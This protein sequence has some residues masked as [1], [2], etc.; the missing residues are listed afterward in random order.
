MTES[1]SE[2]GAAWEEG[3]CNG[4][5]SSDCKGKCC[6]WLSPPCWCAWPTCKGKLQ[7]CDSKSFSSLL[8]PDQANCDDIKQNRKEGMRTQHM[9]FTAAARADNVCC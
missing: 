7:K 9:W 1:G 3:G 2:R 8:H 6:C 5:G 4:A